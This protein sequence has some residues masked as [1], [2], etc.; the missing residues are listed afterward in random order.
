MTKAYPLTKVAR[1][2]LQPCYRPCLYP[3]LLQLH[4]CHRP[5]DVLFLPS[6]ALP[7]RRH[8]CAGNGR[9]RMFACGV[10]VRVVCVHGCPGMHAARMPEHRP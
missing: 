2:P 7:A 1:Y 5:G 8:I 6:A 4:M 10:C 3:M 9:R